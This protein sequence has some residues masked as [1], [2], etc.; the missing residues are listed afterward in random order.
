[1]ASGHRWE[2]LETLVFQCQGVS[3]EDFKVLV[4]G[5]T[6]L[7]ELDLW[8]SAIKLEQWKILK[9]LA[10]RHLNTLRI[11]DLRVKFFPSAGHVV[12][13]VLCLMPSLSIFRSNICFKGTDLDGRPWVCRGLRELMLSPSFI[14]PK[15]QTEMFSRI[16]E[17]TELEFFV[18]GPPYY[19]YEGGEAARLTLQH[20]LGVLWPLRHFREFAFHTTFTQDHW[21]KPEA[22]W[23][24]KHW[25][26]LKRVAGVEMNDHAAYTLRHVS[27]KANWA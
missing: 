21:R 6:R 17:L 9:E 3:A 12:Q 10:P 13:D 2:R 14:K 7:T 26:E 16:A 15:F 25:P 22:L 11:L 4:E 18:C 27:F 8:N 19:G 1:M 23:V 20:S 24:L 5:T